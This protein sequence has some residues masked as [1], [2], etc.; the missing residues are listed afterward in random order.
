MYAFKR[1]CV[2]TCV[3]VSIC[4][5]VSVYTLL[6]LALRPSVGPFIRCVAPYLHN[7]KRAAK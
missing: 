1:S 6:K 2:R 4:V 5:F 7:Y 3:F